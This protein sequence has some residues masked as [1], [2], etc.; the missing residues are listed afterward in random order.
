M[1]G[2]SHLG[3][4]TEVGIEGSKFE[5]I[6]PARP[7][8]ERIPSALPDVLDAAQE[9]LPVD[10]TAQPDA[11]G[12]HV[13]LEFPSRPMQIRDASPSGLFRWRW[14]NSAAGCLVLQPEQ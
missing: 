3:A 4:G 11:R 9:P 12:L 13:H 5:R 2:A 7:L 6:F 8:Q 1:P 14:E 10:A